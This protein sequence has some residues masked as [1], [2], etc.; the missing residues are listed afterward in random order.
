MIKKTW[1]FLEISSQLG[2]C[3]LEIESSCFYE[4][5]TVSFQFHNQDNKYILTILIEPVTNP[6]D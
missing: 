1:E 6:C 2:N 4:H 3:C 5:P